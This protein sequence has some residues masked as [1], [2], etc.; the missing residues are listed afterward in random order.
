MVDDILSKLVM[1][2][3]H[4]SPFSTQFTA[5]A[6]ALGAFSKYHTIADVTPM[7]FTTVKDIAVCVCWACHPGG[8]FDHDEFLAKDK[9]KG[10]FKV[11]NKD[12]T[13]NLNQH[14]THVHKTEDKPF[15][16]HIIFSANA[17]QDAWKSAVQAVIKKTLEDVGFHCVYGHLELMQNLDDTFKAAVPLQQQKRKRPRTQPQSDSEVQSALIPIQPAVV[18]KYKRI[19]DD[20]EL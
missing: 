6:K 8:V 13:Q 2:L 4:I 5:Q 7:C 16:K 9:M 20:Q 14:F 12:I 3:S 15:E 11:R 19:V 18:T 1:E 10:V 17:H